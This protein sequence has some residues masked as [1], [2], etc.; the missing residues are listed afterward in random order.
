MNHE[1]RL[2]LIANSDLEKEFEM[3]DH[4]QLPKMNDKE[5]A[6]WHSKWPPQSPFYI[7]GLNEWNKRLIRDQIKATRFAAWF[8]LLAVVVGTILGAMLNRF[9]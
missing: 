7:L 2:K 4:R 8:G 5:L 3:F 6:A 9:F 1:D